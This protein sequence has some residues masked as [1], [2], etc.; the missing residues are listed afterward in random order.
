MI[1]YP[2]NPQKAKQLLAKAGYSNGFDTDI[3]AY[4]E[5][6][7]AEAI[8]S[9]LRQVGIRAR[10]HYVQFPVMADILISGKV[11]MVFNTWGLFSI[12][13]ATAFTTQYFG[14]KGNN[15]WKDP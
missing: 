9:Y 4:R 6:K 5:R 14:G 1:N 15:I 11:P 7:Y 10:L 8:I 2:F 3:W 12:N 13:D